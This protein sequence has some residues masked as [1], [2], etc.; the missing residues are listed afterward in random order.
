M[1]AH[2]GIRFNDDQGVYPVR[3]QTAERHP[4]G[5]VKPAWLFMVEHDELL[6][7]RSHLH[8]EAVTA[9]EEC[10]AVGEHREHER[11]HHLSS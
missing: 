4:K 11:Y 8:A 5:S 7:L 1:P 3:P 10:A 6:A 9:D 2:D